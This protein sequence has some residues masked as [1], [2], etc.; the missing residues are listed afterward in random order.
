MFV[1]QCFC[2]HT[3]ILAKQQVQSL[4]FL[5]SKYK[6]MSLILEG[7]VLNETAKS[8]GN[9]LWSYALTLVK[10]LCGSSIRKS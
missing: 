3:Q 2:T 7:L 9:A 5:P 1:V 10:N 4:N 6:H 8:Q